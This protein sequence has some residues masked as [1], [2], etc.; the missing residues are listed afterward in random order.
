MPKGRR[1]THRNSSGKKLN[2]DV[3]D[4]KTLFQEVQ[5]SER[6]QRSELERR[7]GKDK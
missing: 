2:A 1:T 7:R 6:A 5:T 4:S 3:R